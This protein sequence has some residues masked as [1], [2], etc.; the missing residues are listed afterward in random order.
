MADNV[1]PA[2]ADARKMLSDFM[3]KHRAATIP[4]ILFVCV[5]WAVDHGGAAI[6]LETMKG[7]TA[8]LLDLEIE[9]RRGAS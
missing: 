9:R 8:L 2:L 6:M 5:E 4:T 7:A 3:E 1:E